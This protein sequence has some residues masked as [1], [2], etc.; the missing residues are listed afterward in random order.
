MKFARLK[1]SAEQKRKLKKGLTIRINKSHFAKE[2]EGIALVVHPHK[3]NA[4]IKSFEDDRGMMFALDDKE[5]D[6][7]ANPDDI[8]DE[9]VADE[10]EGSGLMAGGGKK[11]KNLTKEEKKAKKKKRRR[12][13][14]ASNPFVQLSRKTD[15]ASRE[16]SRKASEAGREIGKVGYDIEQGAKDTGYAIQEQAEEVGKTMKGI[17][18]A[19][20]GK[21]ATRALLD[22]GYELKDVAMEVGEDLIKEVE[23]M[24]DEI[25]GEFLEEFQELTDEV[26]DTIR[27]LDK[28]SKL[29]SRNI[30]PDKWGNLIKEIPRYYRAELRDGPVGEMLREAI[31]QGSK[32]V[33]E[34]AIKAMYANPYTAP[35]APAAE[36]AYIVY[37]KDAIEELVKVSG[38]GLRAGGDGMRA[39]GD[40]LSAG[41]GFK[42]PKTPDDIRRMID[43]LKK[44]MKKTI[45]GI[46]IR[47][48]KKKIEMLKKQLRKLE[49][50]GLSAGGQLELETR[51]E[52]PNYILKKQKD[53][54][55]TIGRGHCCR[56]EHHKTV[57]RG[58]DIKGIK[59]APAT[60]ANVKARPL[61][62]ISILNKSI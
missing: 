32:Y 16:V 44:E 57:G 20:L 28:A 21:R 13:E 48:I 55:M 2:G 1:L 3:Y 34:S 9:E 15:E 45:G 39:G 52:I 51:P 22:M 54:P 46:G 36:A 50:H 31:R 41:G 11:W 25:L 37:G 19:V 56:K 27:K 42:I 53:L 35:L 59:S 62:T 40:G 7:N 29:I 47:E 4:M 61:A 18:K 17:S 10:I 60:H 23:S 14:K 33:M 30:S 24:G 12:K 5:L 43:K 8:D 49:G 26:K 38:A 6:V 58:T